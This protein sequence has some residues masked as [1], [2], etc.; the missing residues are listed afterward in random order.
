MKLPAKILAVPTIFLLGYLAVRLINQ[1]LM[2]SNFPLDGSSQDYCSHIANLFFLGKYGFHAAV[3][4]WYDG[5]Y[6]LFK[7]Y[8]F[9]WHFFSLPF[10]KITGDATAAAFISL[11]AM[12]FIGFLLIWK[13][14]SIIKISR[15]ARMVFFAFFF[16]NP[17]AIGVFLKLGKLPEMFGWLVFF[18]LASLLYYYK[19]KNVDLQFAALFTGIM[20]LLFYSH[21]LVFITSFVFVAGFLFYKL[22]KKEFKFVFAA[23][24]CGAIVLILATP[25]LLNLLDAS[26]ADKYAV[27]NS[28]SF[29]PLKW[30]LLNNASSL[31]DKLFSTAAPLAFLFLFALSYL[32]K[33]IKDEFMFYSLP[34]AFAAIYLLRWPAY[35]PIINRA[36]PDMYGMLFL[37]YSLV[38]LFKLDTEKLHKL[39]RTGLSAALIILP[40]A[41]IVAST[42]ITPWFSTHSET[43]S[44]TI[45][46]LDNVNGKFIV[47][48]SPVTEVRDACVYSYGAIYKNLKTPLGWS[49]IAIPK[50]SAEL[51]RAVSIAAKADNCKELQLA[52]HN[53]GVGVTDLV[54]YGAHC[55]ALELC[56]NSKIIKTNACLMKL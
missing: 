13:F 51:T 49:P 29:Y 32:T 1:S 35:F 9:A 52:A 20:T 4:N 50:A 24:A 2:I 45:S 25:L 46:L 48:G 38:M 33:K 6:I 39:L 31:N 5:N 17:V 21:T 3:P 18:G 54:L 53:T 7:Y 26:N 42:I 19:N 16:V 14:G 43:A 47:I 40:I 41:G 10:L 8:P 37:F 56:F 30:L 15:V 28:G 12:Y 27:A 44:E 36:T 34:L 11:T 23:L 55:S 22:I